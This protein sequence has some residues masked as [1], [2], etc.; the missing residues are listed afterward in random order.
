MS[1][2]KKKKKIERLTCDG[3]VLHGGD[4][5][6]LAEIRALPGP[7]EGL[8]DARHG[9]KQRLT[10]LCGLN[11]LVAQGR[12]GPLRGEVLLGLARECFRDCPQRVEEGGR[13]DRGARVERGRQLREVRQRDFE[14]LLRG[15]GD[16]GGAVGA[17]GGGELGEVAREVQLGLVG[18]GRAK[19]PLDR[20]RELALNVDENKFKNFE[21]TGQFKIKK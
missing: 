18:P 13:V 6:L 3:L 19:G 15:L 4:H 7:V 5:V 8:V 9:V 10:R 11:E 17:R 20:I 2:L 21:K 1:K 16:D 14:D 12:H